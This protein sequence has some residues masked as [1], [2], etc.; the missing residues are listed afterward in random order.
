MTV[1]SLVWTRQWALVRFVGA[2][3]LKV[4]ICISRGWWQCSGHWGGQ[5]L[6]CHSK[7]NFLGHCE[8]AQFLCTP[9]FSLWVTLMKCL[10]SIVGKEG[11]HRCTFDDRFSFPL[12]FCV[13]AVLS[14]IFHLFTQRLNIQWAHQRNQIPSESEMA[15][16]SLN[17]L[18]QGDIVLLDGRGKKSS[19]TSLDDTKLWYEQYWHVWLCH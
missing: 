18:D 3:F 13:W 8:M 11:E 16:K 19:G 6:F 14:T 17:S 15:C 5:G 10:N 2:S 7:K 1:Q 9:S 4:D 12:P